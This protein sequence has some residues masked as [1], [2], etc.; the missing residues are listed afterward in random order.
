MCN[1]VF[2][3]KNG[4]G[5]NDRGNVIWS[6]EYYFCLKWV[7]NGN[8]IKGEVGLGVTS[9]VI[10]RGDFAK[11]ISSFLFLPKATKEKAAG[12]SSF[13]TCVQVKKATDLPVNKG[14]KKGKY[15][16]AKTSF[17]LRDKESKKATP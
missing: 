11:G 1:G 16:G 10:K 7:R 6:T 14:K 4:I 3:E 8:R 5:R 2:W 9:G 17:Y 15:R 13:R 12:E